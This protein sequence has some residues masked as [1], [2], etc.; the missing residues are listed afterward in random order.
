LQWWCIPYWRDSH[1]RKA[2]SIVLS[3]VERDQL[4]R[5]LRDR[6]TPVRMVERAR[7]ILLAAAGF[8]NQHIAMEVRCSENKVGRW[9]L[10]YSKLRFEGIEKNLPRAHS[11]RNQGAVTA[12]RIVKSTTNSLPEQATHWSTRT[13]GKKL[14]ISA[15]RV[16][17]VWKATG[18]KPH[19]VKVL[20]VSNDPQ[21][22]EKVI[23]VVGLYINP[24]ENALV[25][26]V[27][28]KSQIQALD[29]TQKSLPLYPGRG[30]TLTHDYK[31]H[32]TTTLFAAY[33]LMTGAIIGSCKHRHRHQEWL[34]FLKHIDRETPS[35]KD[36][37]LVLDNYATHKH[38]KV[39]EWIKRHPRFHLHFTPTSASW[40]NLV[41][42]WFRELTE[43]RIR[44]GSFRSV[45]AVVDAIIQFMEE[46]NRDGKPYQW[47]AKADEIIAKVNRARQALL[48]VTLSSTLH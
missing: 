23:D 22:A 27:D 32:G 35:E 34:E 44:R 25:L 29:R 7:M 33:N 45:H 36:L 17:E 26:C 40:M 5:A 1:M 31:R 8:D 42:R 9:R 6:R 38:P 24:P 28:E 13:L 16:H 43:K 41:E 11:R 46:H 20:K 37:H 39:L 30:G 15:S 2:V 12:A 21:F 48:N 3:E 18:L 10:R 14:G 19:L 47:K 4:E